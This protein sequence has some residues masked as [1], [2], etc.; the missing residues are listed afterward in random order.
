V[1]PPSTH[2]LTP[3]IVFPITS[4]YEHSQ[5]MFT[6]RPRFLSWPP[7]NGQ[8]TLLNKEEWRAVVKLLTTPT[9]GKNNRDL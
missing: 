8:I 4:A 9:S 6:L 2:L 1:L 7:L 5:A 3:T